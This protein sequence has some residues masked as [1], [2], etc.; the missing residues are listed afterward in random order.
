MANGRLNLTRDQLAAFLKDHQSIKQFELLFSTVD[1]I[2]PDFVNEINIAAENAGSRAQ[3]ALDTLNRLASALELLALSPSLPPLVTDEIEFSEEEFVSSDDLFPPET[4]N[5]LI[6]A[7]LVLGDNLTLPK[8][9]GKGIRVDKVS[10][11]FGWR[12]LLGRIS[13]RGIGGTDPTFAVY[14][15]NIRQFQYSVGDESW[16]EFHIPHD[17][18]PGSDCFLHAHWSLITNVVETVTWGFDVSYAKG[19]GQAAFPATVNATV[20][21]ASN[22]TAFTHF[23]AEVQISGAALVPV[24]TIEPDGVMLV[25]VYLSANTGAVEPFLHFADLHYQSTNI[26]TKQKAPDFYT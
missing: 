7:P 16:I 17:Y 21:Q 20:A 3:E 23:I 22:G 15:A 19:H 5:E 1:A 25:R 2:A 24:G 10:P 6:D 9:A 11:S 4:P 8:A 14:R 26:G 13:V 12:D 18:V